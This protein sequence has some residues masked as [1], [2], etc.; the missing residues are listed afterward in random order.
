MLSGTTMEVQCI[1]GIVE[2]TGSMDT[3]ISGHQ[4]T[5]DDQP[6]TRQTAQKSANPTHDSYHGETLLGSTE[7]Q[8]VRGVDE[9]TGSMDSHQPS[10]NKQQSV[11]D[12][13]DAEHQ[14]PAQRK[15]MKD[16]QK[17]ANHMAFC[18]HVVL[19]VNASVLQSIQKSSMLN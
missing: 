5:E 12:E 16:E 7:I 6:P 13:K 1:P 11:N 17:H 19:N 8:D 2:E 4:S 18:P 15:R 10:E 14:S 3:L 9:E